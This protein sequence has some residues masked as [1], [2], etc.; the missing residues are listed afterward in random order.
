[1]EAK[2]HSYGNTLSEA[3]ECILTKSTGKSLSIGELCSKVADKGFGLS[4]ILLALPSALP[5]PAPGYS[6]PF[7][8]AIVFLGVQLLIQRNSIWLPRR[9]AAIQIHP[10]LSNKMLGAA[11]K[12]LTHTEKWIRPRQKWVSTSLGHVVLSMIICFLAV[13]MMLPIPFTNTLPALVIFLIGICLA[14]EDGLLA[15]FALGFGICAI[16]LYSLII[17]ILIIEGPE[18]VDSIKT[19]I[20]NLISLTQ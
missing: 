9:V 18:A 19:G 20:Q 12:F 6:T 14:E 13:L 4:L 15:I 7:G 2:S 17:F 5:I 8:L 3:I 16:V 11:Q 10:A 1:M